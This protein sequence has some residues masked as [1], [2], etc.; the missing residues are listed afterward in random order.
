MMMEIDA[1]SDEEKK[2]EPKELKLEQINETKPIWK[3]SKSEIKDG[4]LN[5]FYKS[6]SMDFNEPLTSVS[7]N[8]E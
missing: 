1:R 6:L 5:E 4:E 8:V 2:K 7:A 3:K